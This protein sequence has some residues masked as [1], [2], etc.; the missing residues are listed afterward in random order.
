M[1]DR[2]VWTI[3]D[4]VADVRLN[5][6]DKLNA[7]DMACSPRWPR[8][9]PRAEIPDVRVVVLSGEGRSFCAGSTSRRSPRWRRGSGGARPTIRPP[10]SRRPLA[11]PTRRAGLVRPAG[12]GHRGRA[13]ARAWAAACSWRWAPTS[14]SPRPTPCS[15]CSRST[16]ASRRTW[17][18]PSSCRGWSARTSRPSSPTPDAWSTLRRRTGSGWSPAS[19][20]TRSPPRT[21][22]PRDRRGQPGRHPRRQGP[23]AAGERPD[24]RGLAAERAAMGAIMGSPN[25]REAAAAG[26]EKREP[27]FT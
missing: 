15:A 1:A 18:A 16:G 21:R 5:R 12:P 24:R 7:L 22:S 14:A 2:V 9:R 26:L 3:A 10:R 27:R 6:P 23:P 17:R 25:Q 11:R 13:R 20:T 4:G 8:P 19:S